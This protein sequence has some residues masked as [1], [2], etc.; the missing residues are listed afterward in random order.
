MEGDFMKE[1]KV[2]EEE[3]EELRK[4]LNQEVK[5]QLSNHVPTNRLLELSKRMDELLNEYHSEYYTF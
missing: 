5:K 1:L 4:E 3:I 2:I